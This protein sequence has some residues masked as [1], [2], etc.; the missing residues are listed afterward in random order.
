M[1]RKIKYYAIAIWLFT[2]NACDE[3]TYYDY[4]ITNNCQEAIIVSIE[5]SNLIMKKDYSRIRIEPDSTQLVLSARDYQPLYQPMIEGFF[6]TITIFKGEKT[7]KI[8]YVNKDL[9]DYVESSRIHSLNYLK[10]NPEDFE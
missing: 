8:N 3:F 10:V 9:W 5:V 1:K 2:I 4:F 7:S 6:K